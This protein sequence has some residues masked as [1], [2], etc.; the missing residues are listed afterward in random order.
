M[1]IKKKM[2]NLSH[3]LNSNFNLNTFTK[4]IVQ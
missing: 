4:N 1:I 2:F 3:V